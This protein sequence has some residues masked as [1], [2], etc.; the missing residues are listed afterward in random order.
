M[1]WLYATLGSLIGFFVLAALIYLLI[2]VRPTKKIKPD[3]AL[4]CDYAHRGL[5]GDGIPENSPAAF[6]RW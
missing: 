1:I 3:P 6:A 5:H 2:L 4:M